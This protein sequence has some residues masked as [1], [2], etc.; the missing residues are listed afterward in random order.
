MLLKARYDRLGIINAA[1]P[2][3]AADTLQGGPKARVFG[4]LRIGG[5]V[6]TQGPPGQ[7]LCSLRST[8]GSISFADQ[9]DASFQGI[10][11]HDDLNA[12]AVADLAD[13]PARQSFRS[14]VADAGTRGD[15]GE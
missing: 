5:Q 14:D 1:A 15:A 13:W 8:P 12:I 2:R 10:A 4:Q 7:D 3:T 9:I 11:I 6:G